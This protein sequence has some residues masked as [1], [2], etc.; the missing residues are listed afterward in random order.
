MKKLARRNTLKRGS[1]LPTLGVMSVGGCNQKIMA[2]L[3]R[4]LA[5]TPGPKPPTQA[6]KMTAQKNS[7][8]GVDGKTWRNCF[9]IIAATATNNNDVKNPSIG[10]LRQ[11]QDHADFIRSG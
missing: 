10:G 3:D 9:V 6:L 8:F 5:R 7:E 1:S 11:H 4:R 2:V